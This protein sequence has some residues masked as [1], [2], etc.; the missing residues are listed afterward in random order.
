MP[1][2]AIRILVA[3]PIPAEALAPLHDRFELVDASSAPLSFLQ[4]CPDPG[5]F[6][7][8]L[9][10]G[11][12]PLTRAMIEKLPALRYVCH[13]GVGTD[14][15]D[16]AA[17]RARG[18]LVT[19]TAGA[20]AGCVA[21]LAVALLLCTIRQLPQGDAFVRSGRWSETPFPYG[22]S[23]GGRRI[24]IYGFGDI[25]SAIAAR[26]VPFE[27]EVG[28]HARSRRE[29][30]PYRY[31]PTL[32]ELAGWADDLVVA[33]RATE[34]TVGS[35]DAAVLDALGA[36]GMLVNV[37]RGS[38]VDERALLDALS[39]GAI[40]GAGLDTFIGE[41]SIDEAF[42]RLDNVVLSPHAGGGTRR[43]IA[44]ATQIFLANLERYIAREPPQNIVR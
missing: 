6:E 36:G 37:A 21:E 43:A 24:G 44:R 18:V 23:L 41:P 1:R 10:I 27:T 19:N 32:L 15:L 33:V 11:N 17:L 25:G 9:T 26:L 16:L 31:F 29:A 42:L 5:D 13:Y 8:A 20:S 28:Y 22:P 2:S 3:A 4:A 30:A 38:I 40:A 35:V 14:Q 39:S 7:I 12:R 34:Q